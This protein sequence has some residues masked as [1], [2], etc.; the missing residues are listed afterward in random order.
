MKNKAL[1]S[2]S[3]V[4]FLLCFLSLANQASA[5]PVNA[6]DSLINGSS[7]EQLKSLADEKYEDCRSDLLSGNGESDEAKETVYYANATNKCKVAMAIYTQLWGWARNASNTTKEEYYLGEISKCKQKLAEIDKT[8]PFNPVPSPSSYIDAS[9]L[10]EN[11]DCRNASVLA[12]KAKAMYEKNNAPWLV[13]RCEELIENISVCL[14]KLDEADAD[15]RKMVQNYKVAD[16]ENASSGLNEACRL[17]D[18]VKS[19]EGIRRCVL[20]SQRI[21]DSIE[22]K[23]QADSLIAQARAEYGQGRLEDARSK[24]EQ[25]VEIY[26][27]IN[28]LEGKTKGIFLIREITSKMPS[29]CCGPKTFLWVIPIGIFALILVISAFLYSIKR[30][31]KE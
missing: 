23:K 18:E 15:M 19:K 3:L 16:Y 17:Y 20:Y 14:E 1:F 26:D 22:Q 29:D 9:E 10:Y 6:S 8:R 28:Y 7:E 4:F 11:G 30:R 2:V 5:Q 12:L 21:N 13:S 25:A 31:K 24:A 27:Q